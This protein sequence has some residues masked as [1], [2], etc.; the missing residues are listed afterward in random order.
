MFMYHTEL[1]NEKLGNKIYFIFL[2]NKYISIGYSFS[3]VTL[4][5]GHDFL[6]LDKKEYRILWFYIVSTMRISM[7]LYIMFKI[8]AILNFQ[9]NKAIST[10]GDH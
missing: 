8:K 10:I 4:S 5:S 2:P 7:K 6:N 1:L 9:S 3:V